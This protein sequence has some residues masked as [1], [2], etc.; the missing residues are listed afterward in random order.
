[1]SLTDP[2]I[3]VLAVDDHAIL[4]EGVAAL[5]ESQP[6]MELVAEAATGAEAI[7]LHQR[8]GPHV[9]LVDLALPDMSGVE[10]IQAIRARTARARF[11]VLTT[12]SG[13][14]QALRALKAGATGYLLKSMLRKD[15]LDTIRTVH[16]GGKYIP[17]EVSIDI[18]THAAGEGLSA[19]EIEVLAWVAEGNSNKLVASRLGITE[20]TVKN[21]M[22]AILSKLGASDRTHAV[23]IAMR[24]GFLDLRP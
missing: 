7:E 20:D 19:R 4:R 1:M 2:R 17:P 6:D 22:R 16:A 12:F 10:V 5:I 15:L 13:D 3:R 8:Y 24:R 9:T 23:T 11:V 18:A 14:V 21:H